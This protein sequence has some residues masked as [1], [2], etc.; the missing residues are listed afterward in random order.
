VKTN[1]KNNPHHQIMTVTKK[2][3]TRTGYPDKEIQA[4]IDKGPDVN[5]L[6]DSSH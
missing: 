1:Q 4:A 2:P 6:Y 3:M 5:I